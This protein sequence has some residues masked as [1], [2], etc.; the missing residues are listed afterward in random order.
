MAA[1][2]PTQFAYRAL[3]EIGVRSGPPAAVAALGAASMPAG[4]V[5]ALK[6]SANGRYLA[7]AVASSVQIVDAATQAA[8]ATIARAGVQDVRFSPKG[9]YAVTWERHAPRPGVETAANLCVWDAAT[10]ELKGGFVQSSFSPDALQWTDDEAYC[11]KLF[12]GEV[13]FYRPAA[14][15]KPA[16]VLQLEGVSAFSVS[17]GLAPSVAVF[18]PERGSKPGLVRMYPVGGFGRAVANKTFFKADKVEFYW[19][20]LGTSLLVLTQTDVDNTGRSYYGESSLYFMAAA[21]NFDCRVVLDREGPIHDVAWSPSEKEFAVIYGFMP[22]KAALF[23]HRAEPVFDF[24][25]APRNLVRFNQHGRV[26][27]IAGFGNLLGM[28]DLWDR[29]SLKKIC[30]IDAHGASLCEWSPDG[31]YLLAA[32]LSPRLRVDNGIRIWHYSGT[33][34]Y[35]Q[36]TDELYHAGWRP[37]PASLYPQRASLS[38]PPPGIAIPDPARPAQ[39]KPAGAYRPPHARNRPAGASESP[40]S[41]SDMAEQKVFGASGRVVPGAAPRAPVGASAEMLARSAD[42]K[43][44]RKKA[45]DVDADAAAGSAAAPG[46]A[47]GPPTTEVDVLKRLRFLKKKVG[48]IEQLAAR[49]DAG[50]PLEANQLSKIDS[51]P[52]VEG[53]IAELTAKL[54]ELSAQAAAAPDAGADA[55]A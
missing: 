13:R 27:A 19:H 44:N 5:K 20:H 21:G 26:L 8:V 55:A 45:K 17:P 23:N 34:V 7:W 28:V 50:E 2:E 22:A 48:Q 37:A 31:R 4:E 53:E 42:K 39:P 41:L 32:T 25:T 43:R 38:P 40:R 46:A 18:V 24:G 16:L 52:Q 10:G 9:T 36:K 14:L 3:K 51:R 54:A 30:T 29:K 6:Y 11:A 12:S 33:L 15:G 49:R 47:A 1:R 35:D